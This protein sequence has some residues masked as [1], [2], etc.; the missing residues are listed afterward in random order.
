MS[1]PRLNQ[2]LTITAGGA[3][4]CDGRWQAVEQ[5]LGLKL[6]GSYKKLIDAFGASSW[7]DFLHVL[8][9]FDDRSNL[10]TLGEEILEVN[11][12]LRREF[13]WHYPLPLF[14]ESGGLLPWAFTD[15]GDTLFFITAASADNW[16]TMVRGPR[17][18]EFEVTFLSPAL[19]V[20]QFAAGRIQSTI[21]PQ[22]KA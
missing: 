22:M 17:A 3:D 6:P 15:N 9:P 2:L 14:P 10:R 19:L 4:L 21:L 7:R 16:P 8:S 1:D 20:Y 11:R 12:E 13:P 5:S 18:P